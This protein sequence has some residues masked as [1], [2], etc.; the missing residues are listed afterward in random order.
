LLDIVIYL[1]A[2]NNTL[3]T[4]RVE[5]FDRFVTFLIEERGQVAAKSR[6]PWIDIEVQRRALVAVA[7]QMQLQRTGTSAPANWVL[8][9]VQEVAPEHDPAQ[10]LYLTVSANILE[11]GQSV[12]FVHQL[13]QEYFAAHAMGA[14]MRR[15][16]SPEV[17]WPGETWWQPTGWEETAILLAGLS[18]NATEIVRWLIPVHPTLAY[19]C[20][21]E[22]GVPCDPAALQQLY[23]PMPGM[24]VSPIARFAWG[25]IMAERGDTR[26]GVSLRADGVPDILWCEVPEGAFIY[27]YSHEETLPAFAI[28]KYPVTNVQFQAFVD[29]PD[30]YYDNRWWEGLHHEP[31]PRMPSFPYANHPCENVS[32]YDATAFCR[33]LSARLGYEVSLPTEQ[34]WEKAAR[35][36]DG[37]SFPW[38][39][40]Y[41]P[42]YANVDEPDEYA[43]VGPTYF[44]HTTAVG[45]YP[46]GASPYGAMDMSGNVFEWCRNRVTY[47]TGSK[48]KGAEGYVLRGGSWNNNVN[49]A[50][51]TNRYDRVASV[52]NW[53]IGFRIV[54]SSS[55]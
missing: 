46:Q 35:G 37:R 1:Y 14:E 19:R 31:S 13:I 10:L 6:P 17:Y 36:T 51:V 50:R 41:F 45:L 8:Q 7:Y 2:E 15:G 40:T 16:I 30:G 22:S 29:A 23:E 49:I 33:W 52:R 43:P 55:R 4:N 20:A 21:T 42:G 32:W 9:I 27:Q 11:R 28:A 44:R 25:R 47:P 48:Y 5:L 54:R 12:R 18:N 34:Q 26:S 3:P 24:R 39:N 38:G 53:R